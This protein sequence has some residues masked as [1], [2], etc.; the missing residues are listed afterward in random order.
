MEEK[1]LKRILQAVHALDARRAPVKHRYKTP[2]CPPLRRF[3]ELAYQSAAQTPQ[4]QAHMVGC[5]YCQMTLRMCEEAITDLSFGVAPGNKR[6]ENIAA[7]RNRLVPSWR[8]ISAGDKR[9]QPSVLAAEQQSE[10]GWPLEV[11]IAMEGTSPVQLRFDRLGFD[12]VVECLGP[13]HL[14]EVVLRSEGT[15]QEIHVSPG[16]IASLGPLKK[17]H[18]TVKSTEKEILE[19]LKTAGLD[20]CIDV[21]T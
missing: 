8:V 3:E 7:N 13:Q 6:T 16:K 11:E 18:L 10:P 20:T 2:E 15:E 17:F 1:E 12:L 14:V 9:R 5:R 4:E 21:K 19:A